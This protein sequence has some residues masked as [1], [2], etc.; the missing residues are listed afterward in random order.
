MKDGECSC[1]VTIADVCS[2]CGGFKRPSL[3]APQT[4]RLDDQ[5][6][7]VLVAAIQMTSQRAP[8]CWEEPGNTYEQQAVKIADRLIAEAKGDGVS[9]KRLFIGGHWDGRREDVHDRSCVETTS[10]VTI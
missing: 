7:R 9:D 3:P 10:A 8:F 2:I 5:T 4:I 6:L 1:F